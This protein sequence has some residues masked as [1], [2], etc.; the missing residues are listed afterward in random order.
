[1][2]SRA[3]LLERLCTDLCAE[4]AVVRWGAAVWP[5]RLQ[6]R[7]LRRV[8]GRRVADVPAGRI[9]SYPLFGLRRLVHGRRDRTPGDRYRSWLE[10]NTKFGRLVAR[11]GFGEA[12]TVYVFNGAGLEILQQARRLGLRTIVEQTAAPVE[13]E[14]SLLEHERKSWPGWEPGGA[15]RES[16]QPMADRE[17]AEW[18]LAD[19]ILCGSE[20]VRDGMGEV[21][22][23]LER[24]E[25]VPYGCPPELL[26][27]RASRRLDGELRVLFA[28]TICLRKGI[29]YVLEAA[30]RLKSRRIRFRAVGPVAVSE[31]A[32]GQLR[33]TMEAP[34]AVPRS[35]MGEQYAWADVFVMPSISEGSAN[36]CYEA[37]GRGL[38]VI[39]THNSGSV[40][41]DG[42]DGFIVPLRDADAIAE[43][44]DELAGDE[45]LRSEMSRNAYFRA[46]EYSWERYQQRLLA[47][48]QSRGRPLEEAHAA[49]PRR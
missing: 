38:P 45:E 34:G 48:I 19:V 18:D 40:V 36:V 11:S 1:M 29:P 28:G 44:I 42:V 7:G 35:A 39:T 37:L 17:R 12:D 20:Y 32:A 3:G 15:A 23:P 4:S 25:V 26:E 5:L 6:P 33:E 16:W 14:E 13:V 47:A 9:Q 31:P 22:G 49:E 8:A 2:L 30:R 27:A 24:A 43:R 46:T 41:R 10:A 21:N